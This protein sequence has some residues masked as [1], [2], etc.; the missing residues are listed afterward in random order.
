LRAQRFRRWHHRQLLKL[1]ESVDVLLAP[2]T[3]CPAHLL[4]EETITLKGRKI[5]ARAAAG[6]LTA[7]LSLV[8]PPVICAPV[9]LSGGLPVGL[10]IVAAPWREDLCFR[11]ARVLERGGIAKF[12]VAKG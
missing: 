6:L 12:T 5:P 3:P 11:V 9:G 7:P 8:G 2:A 4:G 1:F 10:Q